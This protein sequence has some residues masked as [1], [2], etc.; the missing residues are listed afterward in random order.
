MPL[1][2]SIAKEARKRLVDFNPQNLTNMV[3][4]CSGLLIIDKPFL[5]AIAAESIRKLPEFV[6]QNLSLIA[7]SFATISIMH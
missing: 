5:A 2:D 3:W 6:P 7:W 1:L 4:A